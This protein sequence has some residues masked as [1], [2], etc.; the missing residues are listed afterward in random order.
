MT[1]LLSDDAPVVSARP[2]SERLL[3][4]AWVVLAGLCAV[5]LVQT[6]SPL[7]LKA[8]A[9]ELLALGASWADGHGFVINGVPS[10]FPP[11]L[12]LTLGVMTRLGI[13][14]SATIILLNCASLG[15]GITF[16]CLILRDVA[17]WR[18]LALVAA[19]CFML[20]SFPAIKH[21]TL[22]LSD[23]PYFGGSMVALYAISRVEMGNDAGFSATGAVRALLAVLLV[24]IAVS[25]RTVGVALLPAL[26]WAAVPAPVRRNVWAMF[27]SG[28]L[29]TA[30]ALAGVA[31]IGAAA[32]ALLI[33]RTRYG[34]EMLDVYGQI[35]ATRAPLAL[36][37]W[38]LGEF[39]ELAVNLPLAKLPHVAWPIAHTA[40]A[41]VMALFLAGL[42]LRRR[43]WRAIDVYA[44][45][46]AAIFAV[47][48]YSGDARFWLPLLPL[49]LLYVCT[50]LSN[51][52]PLAAKRALLVLSALLYVTTGAAM[53]LY[54][55]RISFSG[56]R[57]PDLYGSDQTRATYRVAWGQGTTADAAIADPLMIQ[58]LRR[59]EPR[60][61]GG[62]VVP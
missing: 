40:G 16:G 38:R 15:L 34:H 25:L 26:I 54:S 59:F 42:W 46:Y 11:G 43:D 2:V 36:A 24:V 9:V 3:P 30:G 52:L 21:V 10:H 51:L 55:T 39:S 44:V 60:A 37:R 58:M 1:T 61:K 47:W 35:G 49:L 50:A 22:P 7:R 6:R 28:P 29:A 13:T 20:L 48:P 45:C 19:A 5:Y 4:L 62:P 56:D 57:F 23:I 32:A 14:R 12:P 8:D 27:R 18:G 31:L 53:L 17:R 41:V 33:S